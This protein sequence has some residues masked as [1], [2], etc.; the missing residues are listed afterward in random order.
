MPPSDEH[1]YV[2]ERVGTF[3]PVGFLTSIKSG[4]DELVE[5]R[6]K[7]CDSVMMTRSGIVPGSCMQVWGDHHSCV[8]LSCRT[9]VQQLGPYAL[10]ERTDAKS[11]EPFSVPHRD[12]AHRHGHRHRQHNPTD[13]H[14]H[15]KRADKN[16]KDVDRDIADPKLVDGKVNGNF[17]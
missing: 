7:F 5:L 9:R 3:C 12:H 16:A 8:R 11:P 15:R 17:V 10:Q 6:C 2:V 14:Y 13:G 1:E 4:A